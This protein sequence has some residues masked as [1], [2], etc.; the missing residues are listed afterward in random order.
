MPETTKPKTKTQTPS[1]K[2]LQV[3]DVIR[4]IAT[5]G[6]TDTIKTVPQAREMLVNMLN[7]GNVNVDDVELDA[8]FTIAIYDRGLRIEPALGVIINSPE[9]LY[10]FLTK[11]YANTVAFFSWPVGRPLYHLGKLKASKIADIRVVS[12]DAL[13][14]RLPVYFE[15][16]GNGNVYMYQYQLSENGE[17]EKIYV[18][19]LR[20]PQSQ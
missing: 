19:R 11:L 7:I 4:L 8:L 2:Q 12:L 18:A 9:A 17:L 3:H 15:R 16:D 6:L 13:N 10:A 1:E 20:L 14:P 5:R